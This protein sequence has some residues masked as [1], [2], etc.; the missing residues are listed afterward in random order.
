MTPPTHLDDVQF[1]SFFTRAIV[2]TRRAG[3]C[4]RRKS[5]AN[6]NG[7]GKPPPYDGAVQIAHNAVILSIAQ[8]N[9]DVMI[10]GGD[11]TIENAQRVEGST[12]FVYICSSIGAKI[13]RLRS[14]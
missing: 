5:T 9:L 7:G 6:Q 10:A 1:A 8:A 14:G 3:A 11:H 4:P 12:H 2:V 13:P